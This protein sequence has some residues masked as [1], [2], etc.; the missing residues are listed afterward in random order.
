[1]SFYSSSQLWPY[2]LKIDNAND[3]ENLKDANWIALQSSPELIILNVINGSP[4]PM[5]P[6][7]RYCL[8]RAVI[9][10]TILRLIFLCMATSTICLGGP[11]RRQWAGYPM[12]S[13]GLPPGPTRQY[14]VAPKFISGEAPAYPLSRLRDSI[15]GDAT[16]EYTIDEHGL[17]RDAK[18]LKADYIYFGYH[19]IIAMRTWRFEPA[20][21][22]GRP[23]P[24]HT[25]IIFHYETP[26]F[27]PR[28]GH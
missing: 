8:T 27:K 26:E 15:S 19:V 2:F 20:Q 13:V 10:V 25:R 21:Q 23:V 9:A 18:V 16:V 24:V 7:P 5:R 4:K 28:F 6:R 1:M 17:I 11:P 22:N 14:D 12:S 3:L